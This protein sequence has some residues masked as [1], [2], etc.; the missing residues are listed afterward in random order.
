MGQQV[1]TIYI[2]FYVQL[3]HHL[4]SDWEGRLVAATTLPR[5]GLE[6]HREAI[7][8]PFPELVSRL[9]GSIGRKL[10]A[11]VGGVKDVRTVDGWIQGKAPYGDAEERLRLAFQVVRTLVDHDPPRIVQAWLT[12]VNPELGDRIPLR[13]LR[14]GD[15][16]IVGS[17][18][19][20]AARAFIAGG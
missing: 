11:Y 5:P 7:T 15:L 17:E 8:L 18:V 3:W 6:A 12:G 2:A 4:I 20:A 16:N 1:S 9:V 13:L 14:E 10:S 19:M